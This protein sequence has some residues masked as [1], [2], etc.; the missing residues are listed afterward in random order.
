MNANKV[1]KLEKLSID[2]AIERM[3]YGID[4]SNLLIAIEAVDDL[5]VISMHTSSNK[6][7]M[8]CLKAIEAFGAHTF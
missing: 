2:K 8:R 1:M 3:T 7:R 6:L 4:Q 5:S